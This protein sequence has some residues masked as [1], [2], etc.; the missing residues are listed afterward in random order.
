V[1]I[2]QVIIKAAMANP[3]IKKLKKLTFAKYSG[4]TNK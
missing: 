1:E 4:S 2:F 3:T